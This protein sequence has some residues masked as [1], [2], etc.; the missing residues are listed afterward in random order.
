[1]HKRAPIKVTEE[2]V[3]RAEAKNAHKCDFCKRRFKTSKAMYI[4][5]ANCEHNY[6]TTDEVFTV[7]EIV[8]VFGHRDARFFLVKWQGY[9]EPEWEREH[10]LQ[11]DKCHDSIRSFWAKSGLNPTRQF[12]PDAQG[13]NRCTVCCKTFKRPQDLKTHRKKSGHYDHKQYQKTRTAVV[14]AITAK[15]KA[16]Q[17]LLPK[18]KWDEE[19]AKNT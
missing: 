19:E 12:Y 3:A 8:G 10:L 9:N 17:Q 1:M 18:V 11:R 13:K 16:Q 2:E 15:R 7:E 5:R 14:D 6:A 4:H